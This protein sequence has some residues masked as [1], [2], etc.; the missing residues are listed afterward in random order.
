MQVTALNL[1]KLNSLLTLILN[2]NV[3]RVTM[4]CENFNENCVVLYGVILSFCFSTWSQTSM[5][6]FS[7]FL[8][9]FPFNWCEVYL[10][11]LHHTENFWGEQIHTSDCE[12][13]FFPAN[14]AKKNKYRSYKQGCVALRNER[15]T[16]LSPPNST[17]TRS[18]QKP[19]TSDTK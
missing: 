17:Q 19:K 4:N 9:P 1:L 11:Q 3:L 14:K 8:I 13:Y 10:E 18:I 2:F 6:F 5:I 16:Q 15:H 12:G 7:G